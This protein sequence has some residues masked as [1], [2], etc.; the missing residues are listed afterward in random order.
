MPEVQPGM[1]WEE[2][3]VEFVERGWVK[4]QDRRSEDSSEGFAHSAHQV[5]VRAELTAGVRALLRWVRGV[6]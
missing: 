6:G 2:R 4:D 3:V 5:G 1:R